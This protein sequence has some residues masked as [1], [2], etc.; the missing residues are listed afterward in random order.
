MAD[1][2][3]RAREEALALHMLSRVVAREEL[4]RVEQLRAVCEIHAR[5]VRDTCESVREL[6]ECLSEVASGKSMHACKSMHESASERCYQR[7]RRR[8]EERA[9]VP[10]GTCGAP[11]HCALQPILRRLRSSSGGS[12][13][14]RPCRRAC[15]RRGSGPHTVAWGGV[16]WGG[17][18]ARRAAELLGLSPLPSLSHLSHLSLSPRGLC[19]AMDD[20]RR[21][22]RRPCRRAWPILG[23]DSSPSCSDM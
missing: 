21:W 3:A 23:S 18:K 22:G 13:P 12:K 19:G 11:G 17:S 4:H 10:A 1:L 7:G 20:G 6:A 9:R 14:W 8:P 15:V 2:A 16:G 5:Y